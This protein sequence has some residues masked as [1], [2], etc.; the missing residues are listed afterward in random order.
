[1]GS[2]A[3][4]LRSRARVLIL[5]LAATSLARPGAASEGSE[6]GN[7][8]IAIFRQGHH[9]GGS[10]TFSVT[11]DALGR[12]IFANG[13]GVLVFDGNWWSKIDV[14]D[15]TAMHVAS[16]DRGTVAVTTLGDFGLL[17]PDAKG[18]L[19]FKSLKTRLPAHLRD[20]AGQPGLC[21]GDGVFGIIGDRFIL[22]IER[23]ETRLLEESSADRTSRRCF[24]HDGRLWVS[25]PPVGLREM[26]G[27]TTFPG[28][29]IDVHLP[30]LV[31]VRGE[32]LFTTAGNPIAT[33]ASDWLRGKTV[34]GAHVLND[35]RTAIA[36]LRY[37]LLIV[38]KDFTIDQIIDA[39]AGLP[40]ELFYGLVQDREGTLWLALD[41][42]IA[43][44][45]VTRRLTVLD[46]R[47]GL[48]GGVRTM[49]RHQ[50]RLLVGASH[51]VYVIERGKTGGKARRIEGIDNVPWS[52]LSYE[53][54]LL[55]G[56]FGG[57]FSIRNGGPPEL[58][59]GTEEVLAFAM[60]VSGR[61][62]SLVWLGAA[63][64]VGKLRRTSGSWRFEGLVPGTVQNLNALV[65]IDGVLWAGS[66]INGMSRIAPDG[67][68]K[69][70][71]GGPFDVLQLD[72][73]LVF[74]RENVG[75]VELD[76]RGK[77]TP[78]RQLGHL[79]MPAGA[80]H[81]ALDAA[82]NVWLSTRPPRVI[83]RLADG[84]YEGE[85]RQ[86]GTVDGDIGPFL[87]DP[88]GVVW[89]GSERGAYRVEPPI[90]PAHVQ[91]KP[92]IRRVLVGERVL[93]ETGALPESI[94]LPSDFG[95]LRVEVSPLSYR[96]DTSFQY[97][98]SPIDLE[99]SP[100]TSQAFLDFTTLDAGRYTFQT[101]TRG[102]GG[103]VSGE[104]VWSFTVLPP[105]Y[106]T[107]WAL[108]L[109]SLLGVALV[110]LIVRLRTHALHGRAVELQ[111]QV[112]MQTVALVDTNRQLA[113]ANERLE[114]LSL[115]D[116]LTR[117]ANRR[118][119]D[120]VLSDEWDRALRREEPLSLI[121]LDL[122]NFKE[123]NDT[124]GHSAGDECLRRVGVVLNG[125]IRGTGD[126]VARYG[127][128]EFAVLL[129]D[130]DTAAASEIAERL[131]VAIEELGFTA[132]FGVATLAEDRTPQTLVERA[133][134][135]LYAAKRAGRNR[136]Y[137]DP[138]ELPE[139]ATA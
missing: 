76:A 28:R 32:G 134:R 64:G 39:Q 58:L 133:D 11:T 37:G 114:Q 102:A 16:D 132:S 15:V 95:R 52:I 22:R 137:S 24:T 90:V 96:P 54:E 77:F 103:E 117:I 27:A 75:F 60:L 35:G 136:V 59:P 127:G 88:D 46:A 44:V 70:F 43:R 122:D 92:V 63:E 6:A 5:L 108:V 4:E 83:R 48:R 31:I 126:L 119:F 13:L 29:K 67:T 73:R 93:F 23:G 116:E 41:D 7:P 50:G 68:P 12:M 125:A 56:T 120:R 18:T 30:N 91:P 110:L 2:G 57:I 9:G 47:A 106:T 14:P 113:N 129:R 55:I 49:A 45:E 53:G 10:Q 87:I 107:R 17:E 121:F 109:W 115:L 1:M 42:S 26:G 100:W 128:E 74:L 124:Q 80:T 8:P 61:D 36:T 89:M 111:Q 78:D 101:R 71:P 138:G 65:E 3:I 81:A 51:G 94:E 130:A 62:P 21:G 34:M 85:A 139:G 79:E 72:G 38:S 82:K 123:I 118:H 84:T 98:L 69:T 66:S 20:H 25:D 105:W 86:V 19:R 131:R 40:D 104:L 99:W 112:E 135:A 97:R 33:D